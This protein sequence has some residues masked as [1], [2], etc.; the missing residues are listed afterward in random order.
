MQFVQ[1]LACESRL[2]KDDE[3]CAPHDDDDENNENDKDKD[4]SNKSLPEAPPHAPLQS[5]K[6]GALKRAPGYGD[7]VTARRGA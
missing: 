7:G 2:D 6:E 1:S 4:K 3:T 5:T